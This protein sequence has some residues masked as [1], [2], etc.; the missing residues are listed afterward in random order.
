[1]AEGHLKLAYAAYCPADEV[2]TWT[3]HWCKKAP[4]AQVLDVVHDH[5]AGTQVFIAV[6][7]QSNLTIVSFRGTT[8]IINWYVSGIIPTLSWHHGRTFRL[9]LAL[10]PAQAAEHRFGLRAP[11][12]ILIVKVAPPILILNP[13]LAQAAEHRFPSRA[14][15]VGWRAKRRKGACV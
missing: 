13:T 2:R 11:P 5:A 8:N 15:A 7:P 12:L 1:M 4:T 9:A 3:C 6:I 14:T 10:T